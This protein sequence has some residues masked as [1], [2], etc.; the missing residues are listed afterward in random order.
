[1]LVDASPPKLSLFL[2]KLFMAVSK[3]L[4]GRMMRSFAV[5]ST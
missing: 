4:A 5:L 2:H 1:M 3:S